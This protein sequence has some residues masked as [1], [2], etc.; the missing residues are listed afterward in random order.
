MVDKDGFMVPLE[1]QIQSTE[2]T[3]VDSPEEGIQSPRKREE[4]PGK[5]ERS[6][7][8]RE[9]SPGKRIRSVSPKKATGE[10]SRSKSPEKLLRKESIRARPGDPKHNWRI[11]SDTVGFTAEEEVSGISSLTNEDIAVNNMNYLE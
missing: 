10:L 3:K 4:S 9:R 8:K 2:P 7:G 6:P 5:R 1:D 11:L